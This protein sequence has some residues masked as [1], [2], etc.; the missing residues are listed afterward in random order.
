MTPSRAAPR[1]GRGEK[2]ENV[3]QVEGKGGER[4]EK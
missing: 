3:S 2:K 4:G 1:T